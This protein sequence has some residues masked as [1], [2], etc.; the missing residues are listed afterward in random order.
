MIDDPVSKPQTELTPE[1]YLNQY[2]VNMNQNPK[3]K[4]T[5]LI[6]REKEI[7]N[8]I[9]SLSRKVKNNPVL[10]GEAGVGK[11][12]IVEGLVRRI[13]NQNVP[14]FFKTK[15]IYS[16]QLSSMT[17]PG[18][19]GDLIYRLGKIIEALS[20]DHNKIVFVDE[21][22]TIAGTG[23]E[24]G[25]LD[26]GNTLKPALSR[27]DIQ[28]IGATTLDEYHEYLAEDKALERRLQPIIIDQPNPKETLTIIRGLRPS[29][30]KF[31]GVKIADDA[32]QATV[33]LSNRYDPEH[34]QPDKSIDLL[35][36]ASVRA[37]Y[38]QE[39]QV[40]EKTVATVIQDKTGIAITTVLKTTAE[41]ILH[42]ER[43]LQGKVKG[44]NAALHE[45]GGAIKIAQAGLQ[46][47]NRPIASFIFLGTTGVGKT[48]TAKALAKIMFDTENALIRFDM[49]EYQTKDDVRRLIGAENE[50]GQ[51]TEA[52]RR[53]P[54]SIVL[55]D[56][57]EK[58]DKS[59][60][61][62]L[63][64][65]LDD[66]RITDG[67]GD[68][69]NCKN[70]VIILTTNLGAALI[71]DQDDYLGRVST[72]KAQRIFAKEVET[73]LQ[74]KFRPEFINRLD[75][76]I[77]F[78]MLSPK[79][80]QEIAVTDLNQVVHRAARQGYKISYSQRVVQYVA[81]VGYDRDNG[82]RP[83]QRIIND[84]LTA[85]LSEYI[86]QLNVS[87][88]HN[89]EQ[90]KIDVSGD[91]PSKNNIYGTEKITFQGVVAKN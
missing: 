71:K 23:S 26:A 18:K 21:I 59:L 19:D 38:K 89:I 82:A 53:K 67:R 29:F 22:H 69:V 55:F 80:V 37:K 17:T 75:H 50:K 57:I 33:N 41:K 40:T 39:K 7:Q 44:Q 90:I 81:R 66:G 88:P 30:E 3:I 74:S 76:K 8:L 10:V 14:E 86:L 77:V 91:P 62:L 46:D 9:Y 78:N 5:V 61:D 20:T 84:R 58:A 4:D 51:L 63:L 28:L 12:A 32:L 85:R 16:L 54:Y 49:S 48:F 72:E 34:F 31:H 2:A 25:A 47:P 64:Q 45:L 1:W 83:L 15:I 56:E 36:E 79:A 60:Y 42:I 68:P 24:R 6:G 52:I 43:F 73:E 27:G 65:I 13:I 35:D 11:T 70:T 87:N